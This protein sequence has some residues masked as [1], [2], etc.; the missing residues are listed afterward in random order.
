MSQQN[1]TPKGFLFSTENIELLF[2]KYKKQIGL[3]ASVIGVILVG[4]LYLVFFHIPKRNLEAQENMFRA[5][6]YFEK[7]SFDAA[8]N[9][10][11]GTVI[12]EAAL[13]FNDIISE[14]P[15][16]DAAN[17]AHYYA[18]LCELKLGN[19]EESVKH[20]KKFDT[21]EPILGS[22]KYGLTGDALSELDKKEEALKYYRKA[23]T[24]AHDQFI[25]PYYLF[26]AGL[27]LELQGKKSE[28]LKFYS[29]VKQKY[30]S[31]PEALGIEK[32]IARVEP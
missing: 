26:K 25:T 5:Q 28:A 6:A 9:G 1:E 27:A 12:E 3:G 16:T 18:G 15:L 30:P 2:E 21:D 19:F 20:F 29:E 13:G 11:V 8:L 14:Y 31:S 23:A 22:H 10:T 4:V 17:L 24:F 7:D 32:Y